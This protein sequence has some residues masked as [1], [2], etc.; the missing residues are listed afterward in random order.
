MHPARFELLLG[1]WFPEGVCEW[2]WA[3]EEKRGPWNGNYH[4]RSNGQSQT[5]PWLFDLDVAFEIKR[6]CTWQPPTKQAP[7]PP[8]DPHMHMHE[9]HRHASVRIRW[10]ERTILEYVG[11]G[12]VQLCRGT[13]KHILQEPVDNSIWYVESTVFGD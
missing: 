9:T 1:T 13:C 2:T 10:S 11:V 5:V 12:L 7:P 4:E 8:C 6:S 3:H